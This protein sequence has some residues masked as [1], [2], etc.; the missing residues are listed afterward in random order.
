MQHPGKGGFP[1]YVSDGMMIRNTALGCSIIY[2]KNSQ[3]SEFEAQFTESACAYHVKFP[4]SIHQS[5]KKIFLVKRKDWLKSSEN[6]L[7]C[8]L[9]YF[10]IKAYAD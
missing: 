10:P 9:A 3:E 4:K 1:T 7:V 8:H 5:R 6:Y 2:I